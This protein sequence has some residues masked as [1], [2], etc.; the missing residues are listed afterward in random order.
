MNIHNGGV[1]NR[2]IHIL[3]MCVCEVGGVLITNNVTVKS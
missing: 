2:G 3:S 1:H